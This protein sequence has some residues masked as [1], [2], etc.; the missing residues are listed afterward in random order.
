MRSLDYDDYNVIY[1]FLPTK[2]PP[3]LSED[4]YTPWSNSSMSL[5]RSDQSSFL[6]SPLLGHLNMQDAIQGSGGI[7][8]PSELSITSAYEFN[9]EPWT[10]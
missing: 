1:E 6:E 7:F 2:R 9:C 8:G 3:A 10:L 5:T 4:P